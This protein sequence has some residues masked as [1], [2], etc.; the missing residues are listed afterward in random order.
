MFELLPAIDVMRGRSVRLQQ[1]QTQGA[2]AV[3][4]PR[5][6]FQDFVRQG[7]QWVHL[8]DLD[9]A[10]GRGDN[11]ALLQEL[12]AISPL[13]VQISGG[14]NSALDLD[15]ALT[16]GA[17]LVNLSAVALLGHPDWLERIFKHYP[18][19]L[20]VALDVRDG[21]VRPRGTKTDLGPW[22]QVVEQL[23]QLGCRR[24]N[25]TDVER[26]GALSGPN[27]EL[28]SQVCANT[29]AKVI[30]SGGAA[31]LSDIEDLKALQ[32]QGL[33]GLIVGK[34]LYEGKFGLREALETCR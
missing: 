2:Q 26:D 22:E 1:G 15:W 24:L 25:V 19:R 11:R 5:L 31:S 7:A 13:Q 30:S 16:T 3:G 4:D 33:G 29:D 21:H 8:V 10:F 9:A 28:L 17:E 32:P 6:T 27:L 34:A 12:I 14:L 18:E 20:A 23:N